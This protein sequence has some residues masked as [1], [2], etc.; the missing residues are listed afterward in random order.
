MFHYFHFCD[1][2]IKRTT[3]MAFRKDR[4]WLKTWVSLQIS[5]FTEDLREKGT[6]LTKMGFSN[7][8]K[9]RHLGH[10]W[11]WNFWKPCTNLLTW[12]S[13]RRSS[14]GPLQRRSDCVHR[15]SLFESL[16]SCRALVD[17]EEDPHDF[18]L[19]FDDWA[20][21]ERCVSL[22]HSNQTLCKGKRRV[23]TQIYCCNR[24]VL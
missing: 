10:A 4:H 23:D 17:G 21:R 20:C 5:G 2:L 3:Y 1:Y 15:S 7:I 13:G 16:L 18:L 22:F 9:K 8:V 24:E 14:G 11:G 19:M 6:N 12:W